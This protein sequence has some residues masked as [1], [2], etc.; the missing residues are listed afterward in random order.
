MR[1]CLE[2]LDLATHITNGLKYIH[3]NGTVHGDLKPFAGFAI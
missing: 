3:E 2:R 1:F